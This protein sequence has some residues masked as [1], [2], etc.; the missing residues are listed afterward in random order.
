MERLHV[1]K[2]AVAFIFVFF[3]FFS[4]FGQLQVL[5]ANRHSRDWPSSTSGQQSPLFLIIN[6][7]ISLPPRDSG[8]VSTTINNNNE[9]EVLLAKIPSQPA[10]EMEVKSDDGHDSGGRAKFTLI[11]HF[12]LSCRDLL[13]C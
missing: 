13:P 9:H 1:V 2:S 12:L 3:F 8:E 4:T 7:P 10:A 5:Q 6:S 11:D